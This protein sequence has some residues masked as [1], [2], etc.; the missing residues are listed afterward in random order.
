M[1]AGGGYNSSCSDYCG[2]LPG[3][4]QGGG[5]YCTVDSSYQS[6][7]AS[8]ADAGASGST[9]A[10]ANMSADASSDA[11]S[12]ASADGGQGGGVCPAWTGDVVVQCGIACLGRRTTGIA[13][14]PA[15][16][17]ADLG[18]IFA[19]RTYL[20]A[21]AVHAFARLERELAFH[22]APRALLDAARSARH[23]E[24]RHTAATGRLA[25]RFGGKPRFPRRPAETAPRSLLELARENAIEGCIR[26]TYG[27]VIGLIEARGSADVEVRRASARIA[28]DECAHAELALE[29]ARW[30]LPRLTETEREEVRRA[31]AEAVEELRVRGDARIVARL[32]AEVWAQGPLALAA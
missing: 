18:E 9:D 22:G 28:E 27:A 32:T 5:Y 12:D 21:V 30:V 24:V 6:A 3:N 11:S 2:A 25:R 1:I 26:E 19:S 29:I 14:A 20:E 7:Y 17:D 23:D 13:E 8:A 4:T 16:D 31:A 10:G 15:C